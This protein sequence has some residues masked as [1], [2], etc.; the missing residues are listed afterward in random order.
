MAAGDVV[1]DLQAAWAGRT[2]DADAIVRAV[3]DHVIELAGADRAVLFL[4]HASGVAAPWIGRSREGDLCAEAQEDVSR[5][6]IEQCLIQGAPMTWD[7]SDTRNRSAA[8]LGIVAAFAYPLGAPRHAVLYLDFQKL[9]RRM[10]R[11][12]DAVIPGAIALLSEMILPP[13]PAPAERT[14][15][16]AGPPS[17]EELIALPGM[18]ALRHDVSIALSVTAPVLITGETGTG[19]TLLARA[20]AER[21][22]RKPVVRAML[23]TSDDPNTMVSDLYGH[24]RGA[25][26]GAASRRVGVVEQADG[27]VLIL[28]EILNMPLRVQQLLLDFVQFGSYRPLGYGAAAPRHASVRIIAVTNGD[29]DGAIR[30]GRFR[31]DLYYRLAGTVLHLPPLRARRG[32]ISGVSDTLL[33]RIDGAD[34]R[35]SRAARRTLLDPRL[36]WEGNVRELE[37]LLRRAIERACIEPGPVPLE[38]LP[39]HLAVATDAPPS[40]S[41]ASDA[42]VPDAPTDL[43][44]RWTALQERRAA[45]E[46]EEQTLIDDAMRAHDQVLAHAAQALGLPRTTLASRVGPGRRTR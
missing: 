16:T 17:L 6:L 29:L 4:G 3:L 40:P 24:E 46:R 38:L 1:Q 44:A 13:R 36:P 14:Q 5:S 18:R 39:R 27:G 31:Q 28:D 30:A 22:E 7:A 32:D 19:K 34:W 23:G 26:S 9:S 37:A 43:A 20:L 35:L 15:V 45:V 41:A 11:G 8:Q 42:L 33:R 21:M 12:L 2:I 25:F 10:G